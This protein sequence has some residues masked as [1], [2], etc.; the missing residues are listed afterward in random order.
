MIFLNPSCF[1]VSQII[2]GCN[3]NVFNFLQKVKMNI[4]QIFRF[5]DQTDIN[6]VIF[7]QFSG[8]IGGLAGDGNG[9]MRV[10]P[11]KFFQVRQKQI[12]AER[13]ADTDF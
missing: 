1:Q 13:G 2:F 12:F 6:F 4:F 8:I 11:D 9:N 10:L 7:Q 5:P 3:E